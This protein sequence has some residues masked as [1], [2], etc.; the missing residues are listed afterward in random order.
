MKFTQNTFDT[1]KMIK[2]RVSRVDSG[3]N[4]VSHRLKH[5]GADS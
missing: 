4:T 1:L 2:K 3:G 5:I